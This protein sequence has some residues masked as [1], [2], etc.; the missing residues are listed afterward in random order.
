M[1]CDEEAVHILA[2]MD[3]NC[4][5]RKAR[6]FFR[7]LKTGCNDLIKG[8]K[9]PCTIRVHL[10]SSSMASCLRQYLLEPASTLASRSAICQRARWSCATRPIPNSSQD[11]DCTVAISHH[12]R[13]WLS[14][15]SIF[16][17]IIL[18][19]VCG[20]T[21]TNGKTEC[22]SSWWARRTG[23]SDSSPHAEHRLIL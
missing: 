5:R 15:F 20:A 4:L 17:A 23:I 16:D 3:W 12:L 2:R 9:V 10:T 19:K 8:L 7:Q 13:L 21:V 18:S 6:D 22:C 1:P 11:G 14:C